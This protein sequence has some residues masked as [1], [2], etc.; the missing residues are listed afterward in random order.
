[1]TPTLTTASPQGKKRKKSVGESSSPQK[2]LEPESH[3]ENPKH[4]DDD[5]DKEEE[6]V[7]RWIVWRLGVRRCRH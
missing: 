6:K 1:M 2:T 7:M 5:D 3:K 4:V